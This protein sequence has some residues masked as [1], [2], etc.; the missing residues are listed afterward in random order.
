MV[1]KL[2][3]FLITATIFSGIHS[4]AGAESVNV[5]FRDSAAV[6]DTVIYLE[7]VADIQSENAALTKKIGR[8]AVGQA[9]PPGYSRLVNGNDAIHHFVESRFS[10]IRINVLKSAR[11]RVSTRFR[12]HNCA[13]F[14]QEIHA[15]LKENLNWKPDEWICEIEEKPFIVLDKSFRV[16]VDGLENPFSHGPVQLKMR[17]IHE[18]NVQNVAFTCRIKV[19]APVVVAN[20]PIQRE[21]IISPGDVRIERVDITRMRYDPFRDVSAVIGMRCARMVREGSVLNHMMVKEKPV[22]RKGEQVY[23]RLATDAIR[24]SVPARARE[25]GKRGESIWVENIQ[26]QKLV[27]V[28]IAGEGHVVMSMKGAL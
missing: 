1:K 26:T 5:R 13:E 19:K 27:R 24:I 20:R 23:I 28:E 25:S 21:R 11:V 15:Y 18:G 2:K 4:A 22:V 8:V 16:E 10:N 9:A 12:R 3:T 14:E 17:I 6:N 7:D